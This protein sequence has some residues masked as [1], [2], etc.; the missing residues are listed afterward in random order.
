MEHDDR[1]QWPFFDD[2]HRRL[3]AEAGKWAVATFADGAHPSER[4]DVDRRC[5]ELV[6]RLGKAGLLRHCLRAADGGFG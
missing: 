2:A 3:A 4:A 5:R 6:G 1:M